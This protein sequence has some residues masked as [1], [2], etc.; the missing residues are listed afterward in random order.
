MDELKEK[1]VLI[2]IINTKNL[3]IV[4]FLGT[5]DRQGRHD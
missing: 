3:N 5:I 4:N 2:L 1:R